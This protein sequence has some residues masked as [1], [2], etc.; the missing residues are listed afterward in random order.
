M[1]TQE[2][3]SRMKKGLGVRL[4]SEKSYKHEKLQNSKI[5]LMIFK[6]HETFIEI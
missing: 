1:A 5:Y 2:E 4:S 6:N 3:F